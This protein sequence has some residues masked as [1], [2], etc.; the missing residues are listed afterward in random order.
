MSELTD[1]KL[2]SNPFNIS[3]AET[4]KN[5]VTLISTKTSFFSCNML[6][7]ESSVEVQK[8]FD[9][10]D[11]TDVLMYYQKCDK[12]N[13]LIYDSD[14]NQVRPFEPDEKLEVIA[15][16]GKPLLVSFN[17]TLNF[18]AAKFENDDANSVHVL[19]SE[20]NFEITADC[21]GLRSIDSILFL[22]STLTLWDF[23][24]SLCVVL[25]QSCNGNMSKWICVG[26]VHVT[27]EDAPTDTKLLCVQFVNGSTAIVVVELQT[28]D[29]LL[30]Y[31]IDELDFLNKIP[32][33]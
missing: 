27:F 5:Y 14:Q 12:V 23:E 31:W 28:P 15:C 33:L 10:L 9:G 30:A 11:Q 21:H 7:N 25:R 1:I 20:G 17:T 13:C 2:V 18:M 16:R 4:M 32:K 19:S 8:L 6:S 29:N 3:P 24:R 22:S 26:V